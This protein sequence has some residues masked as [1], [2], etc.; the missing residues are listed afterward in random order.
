MSQGFRIP[1]L[2]NRVH[3]RR[4]SNF[5]YDAQECMLSELNY[6]RGEI[7]AMIALLSVCV[8]V[9]L[10]CL[11]SGGIC[12]KKKKKGDQNLCIQHVCEDTLNYFSSVLRHPL[13]TYTHTHYMLTRSLCT[14][15]RAAKA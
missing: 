8:C 4:S 1:L 14:T 7:R 10:G 15:V 13:C 9:C 5:K 6:A 12:L 3:P 2:V 11:P